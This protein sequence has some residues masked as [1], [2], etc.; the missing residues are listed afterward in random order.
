MM[1]T[2]RIQASRTCEVALTDT[3]VRA[4]SVDT[5][6]AMVTLVVLAVVCVYVTHVACPAYSTY[7]V[8]SHLRFAS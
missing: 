8:T 5:L 6:A 2:P 7:D 3:R 1:W 4:C